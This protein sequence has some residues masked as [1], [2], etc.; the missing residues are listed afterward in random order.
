MEKNEF[1]NIAIALLVMTFII[2]FSEFTITSFIYGFI[3]SIILLVIFI[4]TQK[5]VADQLGIDIK[6]RLWSFRRY[7]LRWQDKFDWDFPAWIVFPLILVVLSDGLLKWTAIL[8]FDSKKAAK[9][10]AKKFEEIKEFDLALIASST[11][12][13]T[14]VLALVVKLLGFNDFASV[15]CWFAL[16][17]ILPFGNMNGSKIFFGSK[18]LWIFLVVLTIIILI[19]IDLAHIAATIFIALILA[20]LAAIIFYYFYER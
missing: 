5:I 3:M 13:A 7:W 6:F 8:T 17:N 4:F 12:F 1:W 15:A 10:A 19:L 2:G 18:I 11:I 14:L 20:A 16:L 9:K